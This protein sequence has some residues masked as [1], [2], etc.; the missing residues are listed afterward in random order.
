MKQ[1]YIF[2]E[3]AEI[4]AV[5]GIGAYIRQ[6]CECLKGKPDI[7]LHVVRFCSEEKEFKKVE[8]DGIRTCYFPNIQFPV[9]AESNRLRYYRNCW[10]LLR[11]HIQVGLQDEL[12]FHLNYNQEYPLVAL[13][14]K[15]FPESF[16]VFTI[17]CQDWCFKLNGNTSY[18]KRLIHADKGLTNN[19]KEINVMKEYESELELFQSV[20]RLICLADYTRN[21][22][23]EEYSVSRDKMSMIYNGLKDEAKMLSPEDRLQLKRNLFIGE[24][25][26]IILFV[27]RLQEI[28][29]IEFLIRAF[30]AVLQREPDAH[31]IIAGSGAFSTYLS[32]AKGYW[33]KITFTGRVEKD[34]LYR[35]YEVADI[36]VMPSLH[37]QCSY[38]AIEMMMH[39][40]PLVGSTS[41][42]LCEMIEEGVTG[43]HVPVEEYPDRVE[44]DPDLLAEKM[45]YLLLH[46]EERKCMGDHARKR[47]ETVYSAEIFRQN[48]LDFYNILTLSHQNDKLRL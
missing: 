8:S 46:P 2:D 19:K 31:L 35:F 10:Y 30:K 34:S 36:G 3:G 22:L 9:K 12:F 28:K 13:I 43:L 47:Y 14:K 41:T 23:I 4:A 24:N 27:G 6:V 38:V 5:Y 29:G 11:A 33:H 37:E 45:L 1:V 44:I 39:G 32:E 21:L 18:F 16:I 25:T 20:D 40:I 7:S 17:H 48:M 15:T 42:G 26:K